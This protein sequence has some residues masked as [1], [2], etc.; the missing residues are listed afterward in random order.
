M[1]NGWRKDK[2]SRF[3]CQP[4][5]ICFLG[6]ASTRKTFPCRCLNQDLRYFLHKKLSFILHS[7]FELDTIQK[8][9]IGHSR[10]A[11]KYEELIRVY[12]ADGQP[13]D[14]LLTRREIHTAG[15]WHKIV[16]VWCVNPKTGEIITQQRHP[17]KPTNPNRWDRSC[18]G[19]IEGT[20]TS[21][22]TAVKELQEEL[23]I[24]TTPEK[25]EY[26]FTHQYSGVYQ[27]GSYIDNEIQ[28]VYLLETEIPISDL[29]LQT[30]EVTA[31]KFIHYSDFEELAKKNDQSLVP[32]GDEIKIFE[33]MRNRYP[34]KAATTSI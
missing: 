4:V 18:G 19:H 16:H 1:Y 13:T 21:V 5:L 30:E 15:H 3:W 22:D 6:G 25:L 7:T 33:I 34:P 10:M 26:L 20:D 31:A 32:L 9:V 27:N 14:T 8:F 28:D 12:T 24:E 17:D 11:E 23:G 2:S 29:K